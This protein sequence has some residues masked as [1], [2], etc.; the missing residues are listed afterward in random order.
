V[1]GFEVADS[2]YYY[3]SGVYKPTDCYGYPNHAMQAVGY[4]VQGGLQYVIIRNQWGE[5]WGDLGYIKV[6]LEDSYEGTC[7]VFTYSLQISVGF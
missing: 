4:G 1:V 5:G 2:F 7:S 6:W 3:S